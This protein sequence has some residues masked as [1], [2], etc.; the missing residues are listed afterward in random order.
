MEFTLGHEGVVTFTNIPM[1]YLVK[2]VEDDAS[3]KNKG[4][5]TKYSITNINANGTLVNKKSMELV[6]TNTKDSTVPTGIHTDSS[7]WRWLI[8]AC[9]LMFFGS[10]LYG[11]RKRRQ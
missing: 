9:F 4:Y 1:G 10:V 6:V 5:D 3:G 7:I 11:R 8:G 2:V